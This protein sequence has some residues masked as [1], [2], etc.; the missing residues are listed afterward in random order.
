MRV[1]VTGKQL[2]I[3]DALRGH[4]EEKLTAVVGKYFDRFIEAV[5]TVARSGP[6]YRT[7]LNVHVSTGITLLSHDEGGDPYA[8]FE[9]AL[10][11]LDKR[12]RR[13]KRRMRKHH[14]GIPADSTVP[15]Q[16][17]ILA[18]EEEHEE[19][20][21]ELNPVVIAEMRTSIPT[22]TVGEAVMRMDVGDLPVLMFNNRATGVL[23]VVYR[24]KDGNVGWIEPQGA[25]AGGGN[26][27]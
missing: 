22:V 9:T 20:P 16:D 4:V 11:K 15:A 6:M 8:A 7:D 26:A 17:H 1:S 3:G 21:L 24:R 23:N 12:L 5:V 18:P 13:Y 25:A 14:D 10:E 2:D 27:P 19:E